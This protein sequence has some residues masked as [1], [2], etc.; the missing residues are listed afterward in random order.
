MSAI[1][2]AAAIGCSSHTNSQEPANGTIANNA[3]SKGPAVDVENAADAGLLKPDNGFGDQAAVPVGN[4]ELTRGGK[5]PANDD[6]LM[7][8]YPDDPD[9]VNPITTNDE[10]S[11]T[12]MRQVYESLA[13]R[14]FD[15][16]D[17]WEPV[18]AESW[19]YNAKER[20]Y[21][22]HLRKGVKWQPITLP[23]GKE[24]PPTE[25][26]A[27]DVKFTFDVIMNKDVQAGP[28][29]SYYEYA[30]PVDEDHRYR[31]SVSLV[32]G[33]NY[34]VKIKWLEPYFMADELTLG[35]G[36][37][38]RHVFSVDKE[39]NPISLD[40]S[41]KEFAKGFNDHWG[42]RQM[43]GTG[44]LIFKEWKRNDHVVLERNPDYWG[45]PFYFSKVIYR[46][47]TNQ[48]TSVK[49][50]LQ[51]KLDWSGIADK[52]QYVQNLHNPNVEAGKVVLKAYDF[53]Q[54][55]YIGYNLQRTFFKDKR[56]RTAM[57]HAVPVDEIIQTIYHGF[58]KR[59]TGPFL[60]GSPANDPQLKP[61]DYNLDKARALLDEAGWKLKP[62]DSVRTKVVNGAEEKAKF[63]L[64]IYSDSQSYE[65]IATILKDNCREIG[66][67]VQISPA[68]WSLMLDKL[69]NKDFDACMLGWAMSWKDDPFQIWHS[70][71]A[72]VDH[73]SN[74]IGYRNPEADKIIEELRVTMD[75]AKQTA[76][77]RKFHR[78]IYDDQPY[79][80]LFMD[81]ATAGYDSRLGNVKFYKIRPCID[82]R[83][84]ISKEPR[85]SQE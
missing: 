48:N 60:P 40:I 6:T 69:N 53:P 19:E 14:R 64:M 30:H 27:A 11:T 83:E 17:I 16:P 68:K 26:T 72:D 41:S 70:S 5:L 75:P 77:Y 82:V 65:S 79:T 44:P 1:V 31:I 29:R 57:G 35:Q 12:L 63:D 81:Q 37:I 34:A 47:I 45:H 4:R 67:I 78:I 39:G 21:T 15:N 3:G 51:N 38:P 9:S 46:C 73:T 58:A 49:E 76:L 55:R 62:G 13:D 80:F 84:W 74:S 20:E 36:V 56:V 71:Q 85:G 61:L 24:L 2:A 43:C 28:T 33:D 10:I 25:V 59:I 52:D 66:V 22:I 23:N 54:Y 18:L 32:P 50:M 7:F 8:A 42:N